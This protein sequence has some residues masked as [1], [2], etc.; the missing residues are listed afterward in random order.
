MEGSSNDFIKVI[1]HK[2]QKNLVY[3]YYQALE[4]LI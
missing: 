1:M 3:M 4:V 2:R